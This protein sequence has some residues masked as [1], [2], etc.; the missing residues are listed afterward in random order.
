MSTHIEKRLKKM[1]REAK[2]PKI[3]EEE[4][5]VTVRVA[6]MKDKE[7]ATQELMKGYYKDDE[8]PYPAIFKYR[9]K[10]LFVYQKQKIGDLEIDVCF[11]GLHVQEHAGSTGDPNNPNNGRVYVSYLDSVFYF[12]PKD[13]R[14]NIYKE[15]VSAAPKPCGS[16]RG[17]HSCSAGGFDGLVLT[18]E[19]PLPLAD[20]IFGVLRF[21]WLPVR[22]HL[23]LSTVARR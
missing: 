7:L 17:V 12:K 6:S 18:G 1:L 16:S 2:D 8:K 9:S 11:F 22:P 4:Q 15:I 14:T 20:G 3:K 21:H 13:H 19:C 23:G 10:A 5:D